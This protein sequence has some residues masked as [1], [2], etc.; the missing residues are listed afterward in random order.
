MQLID[1]KRF[2]TTLCS[3]ATVFD[4]TY[5]YIGS[6]GCELLAEYFSA[7]GSTEVRELLLDCNDLGDKGIQ[8][9]FQSFDPVDLEVL[10]L[11]VNHITAASTRVLC[12]IISRAP[13]LKRVSFSNN[14]L[15]DSAVTEIVN[16]L[17]R[18]PSIISVTISN[19]SIGVAS[20][21]SI[22]TLLSNAPSLT[23]LNAT[24]N[25]LML[26][27]IEPIAAAL[28]GPSTH[29]RECD[30]CNM[31]MNAIAAGKVASALRENKHLLR[32]ILGPNPIG[33]QGV[34]SIGAMLALNTTLAVV[35][36]R[37]C[38]LTD[39]GVQSLISSILANPRSAVRTLH[40]DLNSVTEVGIQ[41]LRSLTA[42]RNIRVTCESARRAG[43]VKQQPIASSQ[44]PPQTI[45][46][47]ANAAAAKV[48]SPRPQS[49]AG[50]SQPLPIGINNEYS[51][52]SPAPRAP[53]VP[54]Q[55]QAVQKKDGGCKCLV[56]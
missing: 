41:A 2:Y 22:A 8:L 15:G 27:G 24:N 56:S 20:A 50:S 31:G 13:R 35:D 39:V 38:G 21:A 14:A 49:K 7:K 37:Q 9:L 17:S 43:G 5:A 16:S 1:M 51:T 46:A 47:S 32:L 54:H 11:E 44:Q 25:N 36:C 10:T 18:H 55:S 30:F 53:V 23:C 19:V 29:I 6:T 3:S 33:D 28:Q 4:L 45:V 48:M 34:S 52:V 26:S 42:M 12:G 40:V